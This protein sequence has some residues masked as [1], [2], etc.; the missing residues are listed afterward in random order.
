[1][2]LSTGSRPPPDGLCVVNSAKS[3]CYSRFPPDQ[4]LPRRSCLAVDLCP[5]PGSRA[6]SG[7]ACSCGRSG[8]KRISMTPLTPAGACGRSRLQLGGRYQKGLPGR[9]A[10]PSRTSAS[11][12]DGAP[13]KSRVLGAV[14]NSLT[15]ACARSRRRRM[16]PAPSRCPDT[17]KPIGPGA[18]WGL[19][20]FAASPV[21][22]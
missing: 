3:P 1:M 22:S 19:A 18:F 15:C 17:A 8:A 21:R 14:L 11:A 10:E 20:V 16:T 12:A 13:A 4:K 6:Y 5:P 2:R 7:C 9:E